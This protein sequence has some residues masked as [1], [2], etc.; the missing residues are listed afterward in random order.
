VESEVETVRLAG[1]LR[2]LGMIGIRDEV[3]NKQG[4]LTPAEYAHV[5]EHSAIG[6]RIL[7]PL[8]HLGPIPTIVRCHHERWD[9]NGYPDGLRGTDIPLAARIIHVADVFDALTSAR[10]YQRPLSPRDA[11]V[12]V[13]L[14]AGKVFDPAVVEGLVA[15]VTRG[16]FD[17]VGEE[18]ALVGAVDALGASA[19][20]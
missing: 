4:P 17:G 2:D 1:R 11:L 19:A 3:L 20:A 5:R 6:A 7:A 12:Q 15:A 9:G 10:P 18:P 8:T 14:M 16:A 13:V